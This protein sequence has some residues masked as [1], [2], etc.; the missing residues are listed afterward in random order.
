MESFW[1]RKHE[2]VWWQTTGG[3]FFLCRRNT[4]CSKRR[5][6]RE[7]LSRPTEREILRASGSIG[8][9]KGVKA[10]GQFLQKRGK[11]AVK[12]RGDDPQS[13]F[14]RKRDFPHSRMNENPIGPEER[15]TGRADEGRENF[16]TEKL[17]GKKRFSLLCG[18]G[19]EV[20]TSSKTRDPS[21]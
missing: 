19:G 18:G 14:L 21:V 4:R 2:K 8:K 5:K 11:R 17:Q 20:S 1:S 9:K 12:N 6:S 3:F 13:I 7:G 15:L 16:L 10:R